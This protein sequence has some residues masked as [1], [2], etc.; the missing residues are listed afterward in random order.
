MGV[1]RDLILVVAMSFVALMTPTVALADTIDR[2]DRAAVRT[3]YEQSYQSIVDGLT[4]PESPL[5][6]LGDGVR[7]RH[8]SVVGARRP[9]G[10]RELLPCPG[11][12]GRRHP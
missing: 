8:R 5:D 1:K 4:F 3:A 9:H 7:R 6:R 2:T 10:G 12:R 11:R